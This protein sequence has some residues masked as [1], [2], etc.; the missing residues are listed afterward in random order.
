MNGDEIIMGEPGDRYRAAV[1]ERAGEER[2]II[3]GDGP[4]RTGMAFVTLP[5]AEAIAIAHAVLR[6]WGAR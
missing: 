3:N 6:K 5:R 4:T 1:F 2:L